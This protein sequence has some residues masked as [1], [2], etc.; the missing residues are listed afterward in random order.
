MEKPHVD[1]FSDFPKFQLAILANAQRK[2]LRQRKSR[3]VSV[4]MRSIQNLRRVEAALR[5]AA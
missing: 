4:D 5:K 2:L 3:G 1:S